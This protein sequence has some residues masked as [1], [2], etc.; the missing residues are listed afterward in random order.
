MDAPIGCSAEIKEST[1]FNFVVNVLFLT[2]D[3]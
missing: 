3:A 1:K 2:V